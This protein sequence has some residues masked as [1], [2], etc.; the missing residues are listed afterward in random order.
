[1]HISRYFG[2]HKRSTTRYIQGCGALFIY[3]SESFL[4]MYEPFFGNYSLYLSVH[5]SLTFLYRT[6]FY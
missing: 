6:I 1:M 5:L 3:S 4:R 2:H